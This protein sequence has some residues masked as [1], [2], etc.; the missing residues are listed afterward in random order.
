MAP[1]SAPGFGA[2]PVDE[3]S[4]DLALWKCGIDPASLYPSQLTLFRQAETSQKARLVELWRIAPQRPV[5]RLQQDPFD[6]LPP[7]Y[8]EETIS[9]PALLDN[10]QVPMTDYNEE[11]SR[12]RQPKSQDDYRGGAEPYMVSGYELL[13]ARDYEES[14]HSPVKETYLPM[15]SAVCSQAEHVPYRQ[16]IDPAFRQSQS[17]DQRSRHEETQSMDLAFQYGA[18][19]QLR[20]SGVPISDIIQGQ[21]DRD[22]EMS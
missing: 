21:R 1:S 7:A 18:L 8:S 22:E 6:V 4:A 12:P 2:E 13:A 3:A 16:A 20:Q 5:T 9:M 10:R 11:L 19:D 14:K 15:G 17:W